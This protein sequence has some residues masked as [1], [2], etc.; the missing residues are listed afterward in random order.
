MP[1]TRKMHVR[2]PTAIM[3]SRKEPAPES[4]SVVTQ[5]ARPPRPPVAPAPNPSAVGKARCAPFASFA[6]LKP[7]LAGTVGGGAGEAGGAVAAETTPAEMADATKKSR[8]DL[9][10]PPIAAV[11]IVSLSN[12]PRDNKHRLTSERVRCKD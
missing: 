2:G 3:H 10:A 11:R 5:I 9:K 4:A 7:P 6:G 1:E 12:P 8:G